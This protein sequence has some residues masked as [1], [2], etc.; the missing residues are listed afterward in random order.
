MNLDLRLLESFVTVAQLRSFSGAGRKLFLSQQAV[1]AQIRRLEQQLCCQVFDRTTRQV[2]LT[3]EGALLLSHALPILQQVHMLHEAMERSRDQQVHT[4]TL[5]Y[6]RSCAHLPL[7][8]ALRI[9][10]DRVPLVRMATQEMY[11]ADVISGLVRGD[12]D[13]GIVRTSGSRPG[14]TTEPLSVE[15]LLLAM[16]RHHPLADNRVLSLADEPDMSILLW[17]RH[18]NPGYFDAVLQI[19]SGAGLSANVDTSSA[20]TALWAKVAQGDGIT[21]VAQSLA[22]HLPPDVVA[23]PIAQSSEVGA[24]LVY[25]DRSLSDQGTTVL[26]ALLQVRSLGLLTPGGAQPA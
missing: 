19:W 16:S 1:S 14:I 17:P 2:E 25:A 3:S 7:P 24:S 15:P 4:L 13:F 8:E 22:N 10:K 6:T 26:N 9:I 12:I 18:L 21:V 20:G 5:G 11:E 23:V